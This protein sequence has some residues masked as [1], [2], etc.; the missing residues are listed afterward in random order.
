M[1]HGPARTARSPG[2]SPAPTAAAAAPRTPLRACAA[3]LLRARA[4]RRARKLVGD[5]PRAPVCR[6]A[7]ARAA[8]AGA[9]SA[10]PRAA[11]PRA[12]PPPA[13]A[14]RRPA[15]PRDGEYARE[16]TGPTS[17]AGELAR[18]EREHASRG[19]PERVGRGRLGVVAW[20]ARAR[21]AGR[22][23]R[24]RTRDTPQSCAPSA[25]STPADD[26]ARS[27]TSRAAARPRRR[28]PRAP[29]RARDEA[30]APPR[31]GARRWR[32]EQRRPPP[33]A[34]SSASTAESSSS[35][36]CSTHRPR[37][38]R[39]SRASRARRQPRGERRAPGPRRGEALQ[40]RDSTWRASAARCA[41]RGRE[42]S[43]ELELR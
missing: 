6:R 1:S 33:P 24:F 14:R 15:A 35:A 27:S 20:G 3:R 2:V 40:T 8:A 42:T 31:A 19:G 26:A 23:R 5:G 28:A 16:L 36:H 11:A 10:P 38:A 34:A 43:R 7:R 29:S 13:G 21:R 32:A 12:R 37:A 22:A 39:A 18:H 9:S 25:V 41:A 4:A 17:G 30:R